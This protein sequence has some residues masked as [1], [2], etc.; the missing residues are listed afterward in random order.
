[1]SAE[2]VA[3]GIDQ[4]VPTWHVTLSVL[5]SQ[6]FSLRIKAASS[7][8]ALLQFMECDQ[9]RAMMKTGLTKGLIVSSLPLSASEREKLQSGP[10]ISQIQQKGAA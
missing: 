3:D 6:R 9:V 5:P 10:Q 4:V 2:H 7:M 8:A 1:M